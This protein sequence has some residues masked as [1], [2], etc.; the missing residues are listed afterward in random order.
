MFLS[1]LS[2]IDLIYYLL[3]MFQVS[4]DFAIFYTVI[5]IHG[6]NRILGQLWIL[7][8]C[9]KKEAIAPL[10]QQVKKKVFT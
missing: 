9:F 1:T 2:L 5:P 7:L 8:F 6:Q 4:F 3:L 10:F